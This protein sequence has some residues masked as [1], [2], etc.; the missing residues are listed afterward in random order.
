ME[1]RREMR[2]FVLKGEFFNG[3]FLIF[4]LELLG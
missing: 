3:I 2:G 1:F 4:K